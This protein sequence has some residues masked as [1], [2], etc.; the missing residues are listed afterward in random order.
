VAVGSLE[1]AVTSEDTLVRSAAADGK[2]VLPLEREELCGGTEPEPPDSP[3]VWRSARLRNVRPEPETLLLLV[4]VWP[5]D[6]DCPKPWLGGCGGVVMVDDTLALAALPTIAEEVSP[7]RPPATVSAVVALF[8][9]EL[10]G[11]IPTP[12]GT[13]HPSAAGL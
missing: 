8:A 9:N 10:W 13:G 4:E 11:Q 12:A 5:A 2:A 6:E 7:E 1:L 3:E